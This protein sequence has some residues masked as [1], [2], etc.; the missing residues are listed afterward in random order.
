MSAKLAPSHRRYLFAAT[1][2]SLTGA[3]QQ[4]VLDQL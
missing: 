1:G 2:I 3:F 4:G